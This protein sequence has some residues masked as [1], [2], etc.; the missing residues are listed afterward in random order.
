MYFFDGYNNGIYGLAAK[1]EPSITKVTFMDSYFKYMKRTGYSIVA[2]GYD[3]SHN[4]VLFTFNI[5][6]TPAIQK[7]LAFNDIRGY[8]TFFMDTD[9]LYYIYNDQVSIISGPVDSP[10]V[11]YTEEQDSLTIDGNAFSCS[12]SIIS[13]PEFPD[14]SRFDIL[15]WNSIVK[16]TST[17][18]EQPNVTFTS[19]QC[20]NAYQDTGTITSTSFS[21]RMRSWRINA[22][23]DSTAIRTV[24]SPRLR[25]E[26]LKTTFTFTPS[27]NKIWIDQIKA[28]F[29]PN[30]V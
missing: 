6:E 13:R 16:N 5:S 28:I 30:K 19:V 27:T 29:Q 8:F 21:R 22:L 23:R 25:S 4:D 7:T 15:E 18:A 3:R 11:F 20:E 9:R 26:W 12:L 2:S 14:V 24:L 10:M 17:E 1:G